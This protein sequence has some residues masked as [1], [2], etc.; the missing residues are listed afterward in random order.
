MRS[1]RRH[2]K[3]PFRTRPSYE[4]R[5]YLKTISSIITVQSNSKYWSLPTEWNCQR[6]LF[7]RLET[8][9][10]LALEKLYLRRGGELF[11]DITCD[12]MKW[13]VPE[14]LS[15]L[16]LIALAGG[17]KKKVPHQNSL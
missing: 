13:R 15:L 12:P 3:K 8:F 10:V 4:I 6:R 11:S 16:T 17:W 5:N 1:T 2:S 14:F 7:P 9:Y